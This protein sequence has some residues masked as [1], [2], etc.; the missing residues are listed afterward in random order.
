MA[1]APGTRLGVY[2]IGEQ[3]GVGGMG[4]VY[5]A[6]DTNLKRSVAIKVLPETVASDAERLARFHLTDNTRGEPPMWRKDEVRHSDLMLTVTKAT[7]DRIQLRLDGAVLLA[8]NADP[9]RA[10]RGFEVRLLEYWDEQGVLHQAHW[11]PAQGRIRRSVRFD[12]KDRGF[13]YT[14]LILDARKRS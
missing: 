7:D 6:T 5:R 12:T 10:V 4:E 1:L 11:D 14:S 2:E 8:T 3:I 9:A 13:P